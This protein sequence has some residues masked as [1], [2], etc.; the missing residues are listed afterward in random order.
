[1]AV[2][3]DPDWYPRYR[4]LRNREDSGL[5]LTPSERDELGRLQEQLVRESAAIDSVGQAAASL[6]ESTGGSTVASVLLPPAATPPSS[7]KSD[8]PPVEEQIQSILEQ[9]G[10]KKFGFTEENL[11][12][13][14]P[15]ALGQIFAQLGNGGA[16]G[17]N[18]PPPTSTGSGTPD[19]GDKGKG[20]Q[21]DPGGPWALEVSTQARLSEIR[22]AL[23]SLGKGSSSATG[24]TPAARVS[25]EDDDGYIRSPL[26][27]AALDA[28]DLA[29]TPGVGRSR[30]GS[31]LAGFAKGM[32]GTYYRTKSSLRNVFKG[33]SKSR[34]A[35][36]AAASGGSGGTAATTAGAAGAGEAGALAGAGAATAGLAVLAVAAFEAGKQAYALARAQENEVRRLSEFGAQ[37]AIGTAQLD[38]NRTL[39]DVQTAQE[40]GD[41]S[42][43]LTKSLDAFEEKL[44]PIESLLTNISNTL[45]GRALD[46]IGQILGPISDGAK[47]VNMIYDALPD[48]WK[49]DKTEDEVPFDRL[50][51]LAEEMER[52]NFPRWPSGPSNAPFAGGPEPRRFP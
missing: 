23:K 5:P 24:Q 48:F 1:M 9:P 32:R 11:R 35:A 22:D 31:N 42:R 47:V 37:Q 41:S 4:E 30:S 16:G 17:G 38:A 6:D 10:S 20:S 40:T 7:S 27:Q 8:L 51:K 36:S 43:G 33:A 44:R 29:A 49:K 12:G 26:T 19:G 15:A 28:L 2:N 39:R 34:A 13:M 50:R 52:A 14:A 3:Y 25:D 45:G 46:L 21:S 18:N